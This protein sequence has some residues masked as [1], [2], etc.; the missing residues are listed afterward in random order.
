VPWANKHPLSKAK[1]P[2]QV[3]PKRA[4]NPF[5]NVFCRCSGDVT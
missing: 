3:Q 5:P 2:N 1:D 4:G